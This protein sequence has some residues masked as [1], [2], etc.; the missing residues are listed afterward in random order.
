[1]N[2]DLH[3]RTSPFTTARVD[4]YTTH[5]PFAT[6][7]LEFGMEVITLFLHPNDNL[8]ELLN[9]LEVA[10]KELRAFGSEHYDGGS[11]E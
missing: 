3:T 11:D 1:M 7:K 6:L 9:E 2:A 5:E 4:T 10:I 8:H